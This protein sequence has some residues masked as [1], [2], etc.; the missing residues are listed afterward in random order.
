MTKSDYIEKVSDLG[1]FNFKGSK[2]CLI[3]FETQACGNCKSMEPIIK[4]VLN[5]YPD[6]LDFYKVDAETESDLAN[7][8]DVLSVPTF[9]FISSDGKIN[10][11]IGLMNKNRFNSRVEDII[12][13]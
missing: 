12:G 11:E 5:Q 1:D 2:P 6:K 13:I 7:N 10:K 3:K 8:F 4:E 9:L